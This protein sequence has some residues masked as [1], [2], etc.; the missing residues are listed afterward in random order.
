[1]HEQRFLRFADVDGLDKRDLAVAADV[2]LDE[3][4][5][6]AWATREAIKLATHFKR[7]LHRP[8]GR[9]LE[10]SRI[11]TAC[12]IPFETIVETLRQLYIYGA[13]TGYSVEAKVLR[14]SLNL[15]I[16]QRLRVLE[17]SRRF[18]ELRAFESRG[19]FEAHN[20]ASDS[21]LP[22]QL[23]VEDIKAAS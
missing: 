1:M 12:N 5:Q 14:V 22:S 7:Y 10:L 9:L 23:F 17:T 4:S 3:L 20:S 6:Q 15:S 21:W 13:L 2:W 16:L 11:E 19:G 8:D 18:A